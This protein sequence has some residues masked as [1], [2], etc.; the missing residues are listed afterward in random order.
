MGI[1]LV[2]LLPISL[3]ISVV[4]GYFLRRDLV[5]HQKEEGTVRPT[6]ESV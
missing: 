6:V 5:A 3:I 1:Y 4:I 2:L